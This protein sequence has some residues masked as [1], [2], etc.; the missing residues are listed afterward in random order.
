V[1]CRLHIDGG[2]GLSA[3]FAHQAD[4]LAI[5]QR[6]EPAALDRAEVNEHIGPVFGLDEAEA[7][8]LIEPFDLP[9]IIA[10]LL[11]SSDF[12]RADYDDAKK[13]HPTLKSAVVKN[14]RC[15]CFH[16]TFD[17]IGARKSAPKT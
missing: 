3:R 10:F 7:F 15:K 12:S 14:L 8:A 13:N 5:L 17:A 4:R 6:F 11:L 2:K 1:L 16:P 9:C